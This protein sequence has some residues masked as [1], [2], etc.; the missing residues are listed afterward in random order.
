MYQQLMNM[1]VALR[2]LRQCTI[3]FIYWTSLIVDLLWIEL[4]IAQRNVKDHALI[5]HQTYQITIRC[6]G[7]RHSLQW[8]LIASSDSLNVAQI[9]GSIVEGAIENLFNASACGRCNT[10]TTEDDTK[11]MF[12]IIRYHIPKV[13]SDL[14][15]GYF[16][17]Y[18]SSD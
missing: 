15:I 5:L 6:W 14:I 10:D 9:F 12:N 11:S 13:I 18:I 3:S 8:D 4:G 17:L 1:S 16:N 7:H 2:K